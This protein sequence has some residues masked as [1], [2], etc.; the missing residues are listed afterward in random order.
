MDDKSA[1]S[2]C[3]SE[4]GLSY[5]VKAPAGT[6]LFDCGAGENTWRNAR[7]LGIDPGTV[8]TVVLS[9]SHYD[10]AGGFPSLANLG[11]CR[12]LYT[13]QGFFEK[14]FS[15]DGSTFHSRAPGFDGEFLKNHGIAHQ[16]VTD[17]TAIA[18]GVYLMGR[19]PRVHPIETIPP[20][21]VKKT[22]TGYVHDDFGDEICMALDLGGRLAVLVGCAHPGILNMLC[23]VQSTLGLPI[24]AVFGG[25]HLLD[26]EAARIDATL[27]ALH[28]MGA[29]LLG[30]S[31]CS[32]QA[33]QDAIARHPSLKSR[34]LTA[35]DSITL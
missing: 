29:E 20:K 19:F 23:H 4:H 15:F 22:G 35:G 17:V 12:T 9:H 24:C 5:L 25:I 6:F 18:P 34:P 21:Y 32:G 30:L 26:A 27:S 13:G 14:K 3:I 33:A 7:A 1:A 31:H 16:I 10:H 8:Q 11:G 28:A 2:G